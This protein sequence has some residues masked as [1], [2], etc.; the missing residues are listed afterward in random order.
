MQQSHDSAQ[1]LTS[2]TIWWWLTLSAVLIGVGL[3]LWQWQLGTTFFIDE[4]AVLQNLVTRP[5]SELIGV[6][7]A[8]AQVAP[9][10]FLVV[11]KACLV[12]LGRSE[13]ALRLPALL[14]SLAA[15]FLM[16]SV[17]KRV[18]DEPLVPLAVLTFAVGFTL[19]YYSNQV[20]QYSGDVAVSLLIIKL[21]LDLR[22]KPLHTQLFLGLVA[23]TG[24]V[25]PLYS[26]ASL[27]V[28]AGC[29]A[30]LLLLAW[31][32]T[33]RPRLKVTLA[34]VGAW[35]IGCGMSLVVAQAALQPIDRAFMHFFWRDGLLPLNAHLPV[36]LAGEMAERWAIG[37]GWP[38]PSSI[39][40]VFTFTGVIL[41]WQQ[42]RET[43]L[44][45][46]APWLVSIAASAAQ[47]FPLRIRQI[48]FLVPFMVLFVFV[49]LQALVRWAWH[50]SQR[51]GFASLVVCALPVLYSTTR[52]N[53]PP[54]CAEDAKTLYAQ[55]ARVRR[56]DDAVYAYYG[57][58]QY[59]RWYGAQYGLL[60][61][62]YYLG[63]CFR[64]LP[65][66]ERHYLEEVDAVRGSKG[67]WLLMVHF[68]KLE[69]QTLTHYLDA[70]GQRGSRLVVKSQL[71]NEAVDYPINYAQYYDLSDSKR[72]ARF[73][74]ATF[75]LPS[76]P[77][78]PT[79]II[80]WSCYGPQVIANNKY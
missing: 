17:A 25:L 42:R 66:A 9:P 52:H 21:T 47:Q 14:S 50:R 3:R 31:L 68:D 19:V 61:N 5:L 34:V 39:W 38:H 64:H 41:L 13:L 27:M 32:D 37:L 2:R 22:A 26:Q 55:L 44:I 77:L 69:E 72:A 20:K 49:S 65:G 4:L 1:I 53:L 15:L 54:Y 57:A 58:G 28:F 48:D 24:L 33:G 45:L 29:G 63:H 6:P 10:L 70:I 16:W 59:L 79:D 8:E 36:V 23:L 80:C 30:A 73:T 78:R 62:T 7:L 75:P 12:M 18:L 51:L 35:A 74:A 11:E 46:T 40:V 60:P 43:A 76:S 67:I 71:P 56:P